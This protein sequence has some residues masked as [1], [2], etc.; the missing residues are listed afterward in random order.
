MADGFV[1]LTIFVDGPAFS[2][3][4]TSTLLLHYYWPRVKPKMQSILELVRTNFAALGGDD[5]TTAP[6][7]NSKS[8]LPRG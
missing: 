6:Y 7:D 2:T 3:D 4:I 1:G 8:G 5:R